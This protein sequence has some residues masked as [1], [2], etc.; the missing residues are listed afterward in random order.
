MASISRRPN[1]QWR[2]RYR[3]AAGREH[4]RHFDRKVDATRWLDSVTAAMETGTYVDPRAS[5]CTLGE[6]AQI[7]LSR[8]VQLKPSTHSR[9]TAIVHKHVVPAFGP[10]PLA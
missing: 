8:Q 2:P 4:A 10:V 9:Y 6:Y 1:G 5:S 3:D 7:W